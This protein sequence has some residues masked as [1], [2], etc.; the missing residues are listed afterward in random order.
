M[1][2]CLLLLAVLAACQTRG[3]D[4]KATDT[5]DAT[6]P[7]LLVKTP[8]RGSLAAGATTLSVTG[9]ASDADS[10]LQRVEVNGLPAKLSA[11]GSFSLTVPAE[12]G[13]TL[14]HTVAY[15]K[16]GNSE[17]DT[18]AVLG[19]A[20]QPIDTFVPHAFY[21]HIDGRT[22]ALASGV[23]SKT[24]TA[25]DLTAAVA[26][27]NP[28]VDIPIDD[29]GARIDI[30]RFGHGNVNVTIQPDRDGLLIN[31]SVDDIEV[32][33]HVAFS[34]LG[35][36]GETTV[37]ATARSLSFG[38]ILSAGVGN[39]GKVKVVTS[40]ANASFDSFSLDTGILPA[41]V[42]SFIEHPVGTALTTVA[43]N[44][45][46]TEVP[47]LLSKII[48]GTQTAT[49]GGQ[50]VDIT[51]VPTVLSIDDTG[52]DVALDSKIEVPGDN[53]IEF[54]MSPADAPN[55]DATRPFRAALS[56][57]A[58]NQ[59]LTALWGIGLMDQNFTVDAGS[60]AGVGQLFDRVEVALRLPPVVTALPGNQGLKI[61]VGDVECRFFKGQKVVTRASV[62]AETAVTASITENKL[63]LTS[64]DPVVW[65]DTL[66][67]GVSGENPFDHESIRVLGSFA[68]RA[69]VG[70]ITQYASKV[71]IPTVDGMMIANA[72]V[73]TGISAGGYLL[74]T[75]ELTSP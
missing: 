37:T 18:R 14:V 47:K 44:L 29:L 31:G 52:I 23:A 48:G 61:S 38:L 60:Y 39:D 34:L 32:D 25:L 67:E 9:V 42:D 73:A 30:T 58:L 71:P 65:I 7:T 41:K 69:L 57:N 3:L 20:L 75:A 33:L 36:K 59:V 43:V 27:A 53:G 4:E 17:S 5:R 45:A 26:G 40:Q 56:D 74:V 51:L 72:N 66:S 62:S 1:R 35:Q 12:K 49:V 19:G 2:R 50:R 6:A 54:L 8:L 68:A 11:D 22:L 24:L 28:I 10:G 63:T 46:T 16:A 13:L 55:L 64:A 15:D 21:A 70:V